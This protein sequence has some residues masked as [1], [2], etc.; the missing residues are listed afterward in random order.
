MALPRQSQLFFLGLLVL[1]LALTWLVFRPFIIWMVAGTFVAVLALPVDRFWEKFFPN[2]VAAFCTI[3]TLFALITVP[4]SLLGFF[5]Y[6]DVAEV[7]QQVDQGTLQ[8]WTNQTLQAIDPLLPRQ[9]AA[10]REQTINSIVDNVEARAE[11][12]LRSLGQRML[13]AADDFF[14]GLVVILFV[15][16]YI[17]TDGE[18]LVGY[19]RRATPLP[20]RQVDF[21]LQEARRG[22]SAVFVGQILTSVIQGAI[23]GI[24]FV[25]LGVPGAILWT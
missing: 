4:L 21:L 22:L 2:R 1:T 15:V 6:Q 8:E 11:V 25:A 20:P 3:F 13:A 7:A 19:L 14:L 16:Y 18:R 9:T 10:E 5:L 17:L 24:A 23:G 12:A